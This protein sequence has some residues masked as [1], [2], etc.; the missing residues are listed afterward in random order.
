MIRNGLI[1]PLAK[2]KNA[3]Q[4]ICS[5]FDWLRKWREIL[6]ANPTTP[7]NAKTNAKR[8]LLSSENRSV[9]HNFLRS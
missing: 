9:K 6:K 7:G 2:K 3:K 8:N 5:T 4:F 1:L